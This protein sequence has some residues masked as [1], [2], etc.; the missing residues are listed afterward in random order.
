MSIKDKIALNPAKV[1]LAILSFIAIFFLYGFG[2][3]AK[4]TTS[5]I[6]SQAKPGQ[7]VVVLKDTT[8]IADIADTPEKRTQGL[9]GRKN[10]GSN[11]GMIF[12]FE[13][14]GVPGFWMKDMLFP[15]DMIWI[16]ESERIVSITKDARPE[17]YP[18]VF[19]PKGE[20]K[21][22]LEVPAGFSEKNNLKEGDRV[23]IKL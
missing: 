21:Y 15:I 10:L 23:L 19:Y 13:N 8:V 2:G 12:I 11:Q 22:V 6:G 7:A 16:S 18:S 9:S 20:V 1:F 14:P 4:Q 3:N 17:S 5:A